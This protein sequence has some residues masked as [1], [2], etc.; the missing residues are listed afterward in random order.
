MRKVLLSFLALTGLLAGTLHAQ[1]LPGTPFPSID[2][3]APPTD[4]SIHAFPRQQTNPA[5]LATAG[6]LGGAV[7]VFA[8]ALAGARLTEHDCEDCGL[9]GAV[10]GAVAGGSA[11]LPLGVHVANHGRGNFGLSLLSSLAIGGLGLAM[12]SEFNSG[13]PMIAVPVLQ[14]VSSILIERKTEK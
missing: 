5:I 9:V 7:G 10:Y 3:P 1:R 12:S 2:Q 14:I 11:L 6:V 4:P 13:V 8:G